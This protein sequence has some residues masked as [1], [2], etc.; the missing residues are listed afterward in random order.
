MQQPGCRDLLIAKRELRKDVRSKTCTSWVELVLPDW[1]APVKCMLMHKVAEL[2][3]LTSRHCQHPRP[4]I[5]MQLP[6]LDTQV[7]YRYFCQDLRLGA[8][9]D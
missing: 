3:K 1:T 9:M 5:P 7:L 6:D 8:V 4:T 2:P